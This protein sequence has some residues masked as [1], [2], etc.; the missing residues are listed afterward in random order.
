M[1]RPT[2]Y[3]AMKRILQTYRD[4]EAI[5]G[6]EMNTIIRGSCKEAYRKLDDDDKS[7]IY[8]AQQVLSAKVK[9]LGDE[10][11]LELLA[12][13]GDVLNNCDGRDE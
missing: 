3:M 5:T 4:N 10:S 2:E 6:T 9:N 8:R 1:N 12:A 11:A 13:I 7:C